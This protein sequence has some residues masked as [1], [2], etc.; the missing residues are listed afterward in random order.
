MEGEVEMHVFCDASS[1]AYGAVVFFVSQEQVSF[2][3]AKARVAPTETL[4]IPKLELTAATIAARLLVYVKEAYGQEL[5]FTSTYLW[6]DIKVTLSWFKSTKKLEP[7]VHNCVQEINKL[8]PTTPC[9]YVLTK[10]NPADLLTKGLYF[11][12]YRKADICQSGPAWLTEPTKWPEQDSTIITISAVTNDTA[13]T[14][15]ETHATV[16]YPIDFKRYSSL[17]KLLKVIDTL[18]R[19]VYMFRGYLV[20]AELP[21]R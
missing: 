8:V 3:I 5:T 1:K 20:R 19:T 10:E 11:K 13:E 2:V 21:K 9:H 14:T 15:L 16:K 17:N 18:F 7:Y 6:S 4:T 12:Q